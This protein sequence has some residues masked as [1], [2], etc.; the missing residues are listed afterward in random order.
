MSQPLPLNRLLTR[1]GRKLD[2]ARIPHP[3][4]T[5]DHHNINAILTILNNLNPK[6]VLDVGC[7]FGKYGML[8]R[9]YLDI[10]YERLRKEEWI[11]TIVGVEAYEA[12]RNPIHDYA[13]SKVY[14]GEA[15][16]IVPTLGEFDVVLIADV[17]EHLEQ[18]QARELVRECFKHSPVVVIST[19]AEFYPQTELC[20]NSYEV[21][22]NL[23]TR[24]DFPAEVT[25]RTIRAVSCNVYVASR[26][27][28]PDSIFALTDPI[29]YVYLRSRHK[30]GTV[31]LPLSLGLRF[32]CRLLS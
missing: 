32:L 19:P 3:M 9:E 16:S 28:L 22:R 4:P 1:A 18:Q 15:Q 12:Y 10:W 13:Y 5:S 29:D 25:V 6:R 24:D 26:E 23:W 17:I 8:L 14:L 2:Q 21:H 20:G 30:L 7:G 11:T 31:G 27:P